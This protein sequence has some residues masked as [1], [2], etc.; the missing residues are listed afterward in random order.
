MIN[1]NQVNVFFNAKYE[2]KAV[3]LIVNKLIVD[4]LSSPVLVSQ[5]MGVNMVLKNNILFHFTRLYLKLY[6]KMYYYL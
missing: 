6:L 3:R 1:Y 4:V 2:M 5:N